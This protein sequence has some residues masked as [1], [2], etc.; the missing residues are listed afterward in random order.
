MKDLD[1][2]LAEFAQEIPEQKIDEGRKLYTDGQGAIA[3]HELQTAVRKLTQSI[4]VLTHVLPFIK[5]QELAEAMMALAVAQHQLGEKKA[6]HATLIKLYTWRPDFKIDIAKFP[7]T[8]VAPGEEARK[9]VEAM[10]RGSIEI[11]TEP[12]AA[13]AY[14]DGKYVG[15]TPCPAEG[16]TIGEHFVTLKKERYRKAV[17]PA[18]VSGRV[19]Q[20]VKVELERSGKALL[21]E[22]AMAAAE[23]EMGAA[24]LSAATADLEKVLFVDHG[25]FVRLSPDGAGAVRVEAFLYDLRNRRRLAQVNKTAQ[26]AQLDKLQSLAPGLYSNV[27]YSVELEA[28]KEAPPPKAYV[29]RPFYKTWWFWTV[30]AALTTGIVVTAAVAR[31]PASCDGSFCARVN[32]N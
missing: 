31:P 24:K 29:H 23:R 14:V 18:T 2:R 16:L 19:E 28:P 1:T 32:S 5:K 30:G 11:E 21:V 4:D 27:S 3:A 12:P 22:Q 25:V 15:V 8:I 6:S 7:A 17:T 9:E 20:V 10:K 13:S 26:V